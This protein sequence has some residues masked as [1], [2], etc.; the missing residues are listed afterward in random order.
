[1]KS[2]S[3][4]TFDLDN[5][6]WDNGQLITEAEQHVHQ[7]LLQQVPEFSNTFSFSD[8][9]LAKQQ[10]NHYPKKIQGRRSLLRLQSLTTL[11]EQCGLSREISHETAHQAF[12]EFMK[13]RN[14]VKVFQGIHDTLLTLSQSYHLGVI[15][16]GNADLIQIGLAPYFDFILTADHY[17]LAKPHPQIFEAALHR[18]GALPQQAMH[19]GDHMVEDIQGAQEVGMHTAWVNLH[20]TTWPQNQAAPSLEVTSVN[21]LVALLPKPPTSTTQM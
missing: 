21:E 15:T 5:T 9:E 1:M 18:C 19:V 16:N 3:L 4:I 12:R 7:W 8:L 13:I 6:L 10:Q 14:Q 17:G 11:L 20:Q 2:I